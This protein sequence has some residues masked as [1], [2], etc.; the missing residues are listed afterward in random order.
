MELSLPA[1]S[2][3]P[4]SKE[5]NDIIHRNAKKIKNVEDIQQG[6]EWPKL[7][8]EG[9]KQKISGTSFVEKLK[10]TNQVDRMLEDTVNEGDLSDDSI[11]ED[12]DNEPIC[13]IT[14]D[15]KRNFPSFSF[16]GKMRKRLYRAWN[17]A[18][19][20]KLL[21]R[22]IGYK[23]LLSILQKLWARKG[24]ISLINVG[25][26]FFVVKLSN[27]EDYNNAL[28]GGPWMLFDHYLTVRPWEP[29]FQA[30]TA[31]IN[32]VAVW[33]VTGSQVGCGAI[34]PSKEQ[35][36]GLRKDDAIVEEWKVVQRPRRQ[37]KPSKEVKQVDGRRKEEGSRF[38]VLA[39][40]DNGRVEKLMVTDQV[41][42]Q[43]VAGE[44]IT[45]RNPTSAHLNRDKRSD[46]KKKQKKEQLQVREKGVQKQSKHELRKEK[47][48]RDFLQS[49]KQSNDILMVTC[50][51]TCARPE[52]GKGELMK[53]D[54]DEGDDR[55]VVGPCVEKG[56]DSG[57]S[58]VT[59]GVLESDGP[60]EHDGPL[61]GK[62]WASPLS[63]NSD[64]EAELVNANGDNI[65]YAISDTQHKQMLWSELRNFA[66]S[67]VDPWAVIGD[68]ND[69]AFSTER[70]GGLHSHSARYTLFSDR[71]RDCNLIDLGAVGPKFTWKGP[72]LRGQGSYC[73]VTLQINMLP[74]PSSADWT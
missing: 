26:G 72:K 30:K 65:V 24:V 27:K 10:G 14:E 2:K 8:F 69:I 45:P 48:A 63:I 44:T 46:T 13:V 68:F 64:V 23:I 66:S 71:M 67:M 5:E 37:K 12:D 52:E 40:E 20:V 39:E 57:N 3:V 59:D 31:S 21:G 58:Q 49:E 51:E 47:R 74:A 32:K 1:E 6:E 17:Q 15:P 22:N 73:Q 16:S 9:I 62:F 28:T 70:T 7:G 60:A 50:G 54:K 33:L 11:S 35:E 4:L 38:G 25:N 19:I 34:G 42:V 53:T 41:V 18:V 36:A 29:Q 61:N 43:D 56:P 55:S